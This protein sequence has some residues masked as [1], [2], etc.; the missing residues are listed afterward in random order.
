MNILRLSLVTAYSTILMLM[1]IGFNPQVN[2]LV[3]APD[4]VYEQVL[5]NIP[6]IEHEAPVSLRD[7]AMKRTM[8]YENNKWIPPERSG[9]DKVYQIWTPHPS[10]EGG[11]DTLAYGHK[12]TIEEVNTGLIWI[13]GKQYEY[14]NGISDT[15]A[16]E[17]FHQDWVKA[18]DARFKL[19]GNEHPEE[20]L[21]VVT[22]MIYQ[23]GAT[24]VSGFNDM[25]YELSQ[26]DYMDAANEMLDSKWARIDSPS[27]AMEMASIMDDY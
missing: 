9:W 11:T 19:I 23:M 15:L 6:V 5:T 14:L 2:Y 1:L 7:V 16:H 26:K 17:L 22:A 13:N 21:H 18:E 3:P 4:P 24:G 20:V 12:L 8:E 10:I 27:R 25:L